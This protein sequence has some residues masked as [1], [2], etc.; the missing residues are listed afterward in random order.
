M[1]LAESTAGA[2]RQ[3]RIAGTGLH[4]LTG[5]AVAL[6]FVFAGLTAC[7]SPRAGDGSELHIATY[8][9]QGVGGDSARLEGTLAAV[10]GCLVVQAARTTL[11]SFPE[12]QARSTTD[13]TIML[14][15]KSYRL[16]DAVVFGGGY[17]AVANATI[18]GPCEQIQADG[19]EFTASSDATP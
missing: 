15:G 7:G 16:G 5:L 18:P 6:C 9:Q 2:V 3:T 17:N 4:R 19:L 11:V 10:G 8:Q 13:G 12:G 14:F 1:S